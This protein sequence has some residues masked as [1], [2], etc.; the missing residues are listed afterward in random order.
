MKRKKKH[1]NISEEYF[2]TN[3]YTRNEKMQHAN[4]A[5]TEEREEERKPRNGNYKSKV[6]TRFIIL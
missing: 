2:F 3:F 1:I 4:D 6:I 5:E